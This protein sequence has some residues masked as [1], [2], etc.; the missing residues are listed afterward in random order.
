MST[1]AFSAENFLEIYDINNRNGENRDKD[2][3]PEVHRSNLRIDRKAR[4]IRNFYKKHKA[5][6]SKLSPSRRIQARTL[7][8]NLKSEQKRKRDTLT[9][10]LQRVSDMVCQKGFSISLST[11]SANGKTTY[12]HGDNPPEYYALRQTA[13]NLR[14]IYDVKQAS[15]NDIC[16]QIL[17]MIQDG[18]T[19]YVARLDI[20]SFY[21]SVPQ[22]ELVKKVELDGLLSI[23]SKR[24]LKQS[25]KAY[26][27]LNG[28]T[29]KGIPR[30]VNISADLSELYMK[31]LDE[32]IK[33]LDGVCFYARYVDDMI[34][35]FA[36]P[37]HVASSERLPKIVSLIKNSKLDVN[38]TKTKIYDMRANPTFEYLGY[39]FECRGKNS[40][41][42]LSEKKLQRY[43]DRLN[44]VLK[45]YE[46]D[47]SINSKRAFRL[48]LS[49]LRFLTGNTQLHNSKRNAHTGIFFSNPIIT[50]LTQLRDLDMILSFW[51]SRQLRHNPMLKAK[52]NS[53]SF[54]TGFARK[55]IFRF[56]RWKK[57]GQRDELKKIVGAWS[58]AEKG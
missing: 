11:G 23:Q 43:H 54:E 30:G 29:S 16:A 6:R 14:K 38:P 4:A 42:L 51:A 33:Q 8:D 56:N 34:V 44:Y 35:F 48:L 18:Y 58:Y 41:A 20:S 49:R 15:R 31:D 57:P 32:N 45:D 5:G 24:I 22:Q 40:R 17:S 9:A 19:Y 26:S 2:F 52:V 3:F 55:R 13:A 36:Q 27:D 21:E 37:E 1:Q 28:G 53:L 50:D 10:E 12:R 46:K 7:F 25:L 47:R 39:V